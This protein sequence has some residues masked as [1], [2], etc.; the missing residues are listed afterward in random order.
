MYLG[1]FGAELGRHLRFP[2]LPSEARFKSW[3][4][5]Q[6]SFL[7]M[8]ALGGSPGPATAVGDTGGVPDSWIRSG[9]DPAAADILGVNQWTEDLSSLFLSIVLSCIY[10]Y[11]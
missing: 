4:H 10:Q 7:L 5:L 9:S 6:S 3:L 11:I 2:H 1:A 8:G